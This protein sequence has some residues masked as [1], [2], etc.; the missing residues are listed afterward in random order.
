MIKLNN[1]NTNLILWIYT[2]KEKINNLEQL[3]GFREERVSTPPPMY[4]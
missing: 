1:C 4:E 2:I 3:V